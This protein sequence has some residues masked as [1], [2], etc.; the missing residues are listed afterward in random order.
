MSL[1]ARLQAIP[2]PPANGALV[3]NPPAS[4]DYLVVAWDLDTTGRRLI[5][6]I[7]HIGAHYINSEGQDLNFSQYVMPYK[8]PNPGARRSFGIRVVNIGRYRMLKDMESGKILKTKSEVSALQEFIDWLRESA[9]REGAPKSEGVL[10]ACHEPTRKVLVPL[11]LE[12]L[13]KYNLVDDFCAVVA[14]FVNSA[15][16]VQKFGDL[17]KVTSLS[18]RSLCKTVLQ[19]TN[20]NTSTA[21]ERCK[22]LSRILGKLT[23]RH[24]VSGEKVSA[25]AF[26]V[27]S[28]R[29]DLERLK[30]MLGTQGT[31]RPI[32]ESKLKQKRSVRERAMVLRK[33]V[34][35]AGVNY[36]ELSGIY[37]AKKEDA[38]EILLDKVVG[39]TEEDVTELIDL[40]TTHFENPEPQP[41]QKT[42]MTS[43]DVENSNSKEVSHGG[44]GENRAPPQR[45]Q[46]YPNTNYQSRHYNQQNYHH[47]YTNSRW[48]RGGGGRGGYQHRGGRGGGRGYGDGGGGY[49]GGGGGGYRGA[50]S[51]GRSRGRGGGG[52]HNNGQNQ[53]PGQVKAA[54]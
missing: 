14:G 34:A 30:M 28:E 32:F 9:E 36:D 1:S 5:D 25:V 43:G 52:W 11:L 42:A 6:E 49:R 48:Q 2:P 7:C 4:G 35:E 18:L 41:V 39:C 19:D 45:K 53:A 10:L 54:E 26:T 23:D 47:Q 21:S 20:P 50:W 40:M 8:N 3:V 12:A 13:H 51:G 17:S 38:K 44:D 29:D 16:M 27:R 15:A 46:Q 22:V 37:K 33:K 24:P 31:L